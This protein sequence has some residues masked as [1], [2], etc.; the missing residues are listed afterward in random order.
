MNKCLI[1]FVILLSLYGRCFSCDRTSAVNAIDA[2]CGAVENNDFDTVETTLK[3]YPE[4]INEMCSGGDTPL[5]FASSQRMV[6]Y[7]LSQG[8]SVNVKAF[9]G[10]TPLHNA[11]L[12]GN[13][14]VARALLQN[15]ASVSAKSRTG[16]TP[17][18]CAARNGSCEMVKLLV[19]KGADVNCRD[20]SGSTPL[21]VAGENCNREAAELLRSLGGK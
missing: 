9:D 4:L 21:Q 11:A 1:L 13:T 7:L 18:H 8:A 3:Y 2:L 5:H 10:D 12:K 6:E 17:L 19:S 15:G 16:Q 14:G 20:N